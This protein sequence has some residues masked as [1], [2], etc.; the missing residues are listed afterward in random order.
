MSD[1]A[2][3]TEPD[4]K[5]EEQN[6]PKPKRDWWQRHYTFTGTAV[7]LVFVWFSMTPSLL[8]R[9]PLFQGIVSGAAGAIGY[10]LGV[11]AVWLVRFMLSK[12]TSPPAPRRAWIALI[13]VGVI[14]Q[15]AMIVWFHVWQ[16]HVRDLMGVPRLN[17]YDYPLAA[18]LAIVVLFVF[19]EIGQLIRRLV[20]FLDRQLDRFAPPR[21][22]AVVVVL[23]L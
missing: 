10:G 11:F 21:V 18:I 20:L 14:G 8:P 12:P 5:P 23:L 1:T 22:S 6:A 9:G 17:W 2:T 4:E 19:V 16:D 13:A 3:A 15:I 7:G